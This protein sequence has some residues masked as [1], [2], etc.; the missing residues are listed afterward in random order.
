[1]KLSL[2]HFFVL[3]P[4]AFAGHHHLRALQTREEDSCKPDVGSACEF[5]SPETVIGASSVWGEGACEGVDA[6]VGVLSCWGR[7]SCLELQP[8]TAGQPSVGDGSCLGD[9]SCERMEGSFVGSGSCL[10][11]RACYDDVEYSHIGDG[12]CVNLISK[13]YPDGYGN[14]G[15]VCHGMKKARV[16]DFSCVLGR[17]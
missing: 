11:V 13:K 1:M 4:S 15:N 12:S 14:G 6:T 3:I 5:Q 9:G 7:R 2:T 8:G 16:G 17:R 10:G